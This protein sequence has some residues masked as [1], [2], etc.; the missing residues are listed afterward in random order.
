MLNI[1]DIIYKI[2]PI[3][4]V[5]KSVVMHGSKFGSVDLTETVMS[6]HEQLVRILFGFRVIQNALYA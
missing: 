1:T 6:F 2:C 4:N 5:T 3:I